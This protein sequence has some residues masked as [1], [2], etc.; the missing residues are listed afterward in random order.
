M[1]SHIS[2][3]AK[4]ICYPLYWV[5]AVAAIIT[6]AIFPNLQGHNV[7]KFFRNYLFAIVV[8]LFFAKLLAAVFFA[9]DDIRRLGI[10]LLA[11]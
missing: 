2:E 11:A 3:R 10:W 7:S 4:W 6:V 9:L 8:G 1:T 5:V